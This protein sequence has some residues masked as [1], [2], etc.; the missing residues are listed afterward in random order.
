MDIS[1]SRDQVAEWARLTRPQVNHMCNIGLILSEIGQVRKRISVRE[2]QLAAGS[3][4]FM[5][6]GMQP[7]DLIAPFEWLREQ[8][9]TDANC[10]LR[11]KYAVNGLPKVEHAITDFWLAIYADADEWKAHWSN[12]GAPI[13]GKEACVL[14]NFK[15]VFENCG[16]LHG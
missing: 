15:T 12:T 13:E 8:L 9:E 7:K 5:R 4:A 3:A 14:V 16:D 6:L 2:L 1:F 11:F 10:A